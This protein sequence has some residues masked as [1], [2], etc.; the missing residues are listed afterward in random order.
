MARRVE[1]PDG[2][3]ADI[4]EDILG[5]IST[6]SLEG[7]RGIPLDLDS[8]IQAANLEKTKVQTKA[9]REKLERHRQE[10]WNSWSEEYFKCFA[11]AFSKFKNELIALHLTPKQLKVLQDKLESAL[12]S[13]QAKLDFMYN[14]FMENGLGKEDLEDDKL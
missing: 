8:Q 7:A 14:D 10:I 11:E 1:E 3:A 9:L 12:E 6:S 13:L 4:V 5:D 2:D